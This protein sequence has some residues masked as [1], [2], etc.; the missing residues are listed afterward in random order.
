MFP[1]PGASRKDA[2]GEEG[3]VVRFH[4][5]RAAVMSDDRGPTLAP[6][7]RTTRGGK[8]GPAEL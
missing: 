1:V 5:G 3:S 4:R 7:P 2:T 8:A 6:L